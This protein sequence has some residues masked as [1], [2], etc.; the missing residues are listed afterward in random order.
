MN[1]SQ[2]VDLKVAWCSYK[3]AKYAVKHWHYSKSMPAGKLLKIG[4][5][6]NS[7]FLGVVLFGLGANRH[8][9]QPF[10]IRNTDVCEL[11]RVALTE[12]L[13]MV[14]RIIK[15]AITLLKQHC[16]KCR[17]IISFA[18]PFQKHT[19]GIYQAGNWIYIG[20]GTTD[21]R[22]KPYKKDKKTYHWRTVNDQLA[23]KGLRATVEAAA[24]LGYE[25]IETEPKHKYLY[26]LDK[27]MRRQIE[28]LRQ[29]YPKR[30]A[31]GSTS[32]PIEAGGSTPTSPLQQKGIVEVKGQRIHVC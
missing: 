11:V 20:R 25:M 17:L 12:H 29:P 24:S 18:D 21:K 19:G 27:A 31:D 28:K 6:E 2:Q 1:S 3:A 26:P 9:H 14:T 13:S 16:P 22:C 4:V 30:A 5:W 23:R 32:N 8:S 15:I 7:T 10:D